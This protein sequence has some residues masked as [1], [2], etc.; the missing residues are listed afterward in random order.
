MVADPKFIHLRVHTAYSILEGAI[1]MKELAKW[2]SESKAPAIAVTDTNN[3]FGAMDLADVCVKSGVQ[4]IL[5]CQ[6]LIKSPQKEKSAF[7]EEKEAY[8]KIVVLVQNEAGYLSLLQFFRL[9]YTTEEKTGVPHLTFDELLSY[10]DGLI[11]LTGGAEGILARPILEGKQDY[12][13]ELASRLKEAFKDRLYI[14]IQRHGTEAEGK[15]RRW[16]FKDCL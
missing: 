3:I 1:K 6:L 4:P 5:G 14:E 7:E 12:A 16:F 13:M 8:D 10:P 9:F 2:A 11:L 15:N